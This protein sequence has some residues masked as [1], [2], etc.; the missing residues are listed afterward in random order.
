MERKEL[1]II[2]S[3]E[4][5]EARRWQRGLDRLQHL[6]SLDPNTNNRPEPCNEFLGSIY[7]DT[8]RIHSNIESVQSDSL[9][10][11]ADFNEFDAIDF[12]DNVDENIDKFVKRQ[13]A[14]SPELNAILKST[15]NPEP[16]VDSELESKKTSVEQISRSPWTSGM[17]LV[18]FRATAEQVADDFL[19]KNNIKLRDRRARPSYVRD[20]DTYRQGQKDSA[21]I[22][23]CQ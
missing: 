3:K 14:Q 1:D 10:I 2:A 17:Q 6:P 7:T 15:V 22:E 19:E 16:K 9:D 11:K 12:S 18:R 21:K 5:E 13:A 23:V 4:R 20:L 8:D